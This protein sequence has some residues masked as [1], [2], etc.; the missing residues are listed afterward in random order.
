M[1]QSKPVSAARSISTFNLTAISPVPK[2][3]ILTHSNIFIGKKS[4]VVQV[5]V[6]N[7]SFIRLTNWVEWLSIEME[8]EHEARN[9]L[10]S[11]LE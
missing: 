3:A 6:N 9:E 7:P 5:C 10:R 4:F 1:L 8:Y 2:L 11:Q